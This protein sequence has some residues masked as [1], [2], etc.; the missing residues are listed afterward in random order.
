MNMTVHQSNIKHQIYQPMHTS[1]TGVISV[2][3][4][5]G[6]SHPLSHPLT[7]ADTK[8]CQIV[9]TAKSLYISQGQ[10]RNKENL[11]GR[12]LHAVTG[13]EEKHTLRQQKQSTLNMIPHT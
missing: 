3:M 9:N 13:Y 12:R 6:N 2:N 11:E 8:E 1:Y 4:H 5:K 7:T 10:H